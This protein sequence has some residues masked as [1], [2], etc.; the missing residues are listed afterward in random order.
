MQDVKSENTSAVGMPGRNM[1]NFLSFFNIAI[2]LI[3]TFECQNI[4]TTAIE[5]Q[6]FGLVAWVVIQRMTL[7]LC[8]FFRFHAAVFSLELWKEYSGKEDNVKE[9]VKLW[10]GRVGKSRGAT[11][12][13]DIV[14]EP[15]SA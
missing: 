3:I 7:P 14:E 4:T 6:V 1:C 5:A 9:A 15:K 8:I 2:W 11:D 13:E 12:N 10:K